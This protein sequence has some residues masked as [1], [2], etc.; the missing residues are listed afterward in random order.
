MYRGTSSTEPVQAVK[1]Y[2]NLFISLVIFSSGGLCSDFRETS[3][4]FGL[5]KPTSSCFL[6]ETCDCKTSLCHGIVLLSTSWSSALLSWALS[7]FL[8]LHE[9][10]AWCFPFCWLTSEPCQ[11]CSFCLWVLSCWLHGP[12]WETSTDYSSHLKFICRAP[13]WDRS[14]PK[15]SAQAILWIFSYLLT[16]YSHGRVEQILACFGNQAAAGRK[17][18]S[19]NEK[20]PKREEKKKR[21]R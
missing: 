7:S 12:C 5:Y 18:S 15:E 17:G 9:L 8:P 19:L 11:M 16:K 2:W 21:L 6:S 4:A 20:Q 14:E 3:A 13:L 1:L 10:R